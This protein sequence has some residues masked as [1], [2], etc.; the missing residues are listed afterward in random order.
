MTQYERD[1]LAHLAHDWEAQAAMLE[2]EPELASYLGR[3][4]RQRHILVLRDCA[5][6]LRERLALL[7]RTPAAG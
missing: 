4:E 3:D 2:R 5:E 7:I 6:Q 1:L